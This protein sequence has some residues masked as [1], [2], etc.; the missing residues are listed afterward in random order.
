MLKKRHIPNIITAL[1]L[2]LSPLLT[3]TAPL[4]GAFYAV[5]IICGLSDM[6]DGWLARRL[7]AE[8]ILG[9]RLDSAADIAFLCFCA[10][11]LFPLLSLP[12]WEY[13]AAAVIAALRL[14]NIIYS[15]RK[16][17]RV[18]MLHTAANRLTGLMLFLW[19]LSWGIVPPEIT[20]LPIG[21]AALFAS[22][23][24]TYLISRGAGQTV[25]CQG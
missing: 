21:A 3:L 17:G 23:H 5:Y 8:S 7:K 4:S 20:L 15:K 22:V 14:V 24:E 11:S 10:L 16:C 12:L 9:A 25:S 6:T 2:V 1:R 19:P 13:A 18:V